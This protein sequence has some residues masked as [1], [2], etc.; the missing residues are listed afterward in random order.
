MTDIVEYGY[1]LTVEIDWTDSGLYDHP[2]SDV[3]QRWTRIQL[4]YGAS[5][6]AN[7]LRPTMDAGRGSITVHG[8]EF[9]PGVSE[10]FSEVQLR[11]RH[12]CRILLTVGGVT[13]ALAAGWVMLH[14]R[15][16]FRTTTF[17]W[18]GALGTSGSRHD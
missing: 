1:P 11:G 15:A 9:V 14:R 13:N 8:Q 4:G 12:R 10:D 3:S 17:A 6:T 2:L 18:E 7:P 5:R 16:G